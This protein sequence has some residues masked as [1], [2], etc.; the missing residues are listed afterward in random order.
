MSKAAVVLVSSLLG[1]STIA[2]AESGPTMRFGLTGA[3]SNGDAPGK[4]EAGP[5]LGLGLRSGSFV[6]ELEYAYLSFFDP[7]TIGGGVQRVGVSLRADV[8]R[9]FATRCLFRGGCTRAQALWVE[10]GAGE[11]FGQWQLDASHVTPVGDHQ[12]EA[13]L[14]LGIELDNQIHPMRNGFQLGVRFAVAPR[15]TDALASC[16]GSGCMPTAT[17]TTNQGG[18]ATSVLIEWMFLFG[19]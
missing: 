11:R 14:S 1:L 18:Y 8:L 17:D 15:G 3:L 5:A 16:R 10:G 4:W 7:D 9:S 6:G 19:N 13:H 12:P 2:A